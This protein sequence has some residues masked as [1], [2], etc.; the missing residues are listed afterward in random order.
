M[1]FVFVFVFVLVFVIVCLKKIGRSEVRKRW[2]VGEILVAGMTREG[3]GHGVWK[4]STE[5]NTFIQI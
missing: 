5:R 2:G 4:G 3:Q 1:V